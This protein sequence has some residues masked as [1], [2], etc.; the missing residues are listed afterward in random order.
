MPSGSVSIDE[1]DR[2]D[3]AVPAAGNCLDIAVCIGGI[4]EGLAELAYGSIQPSLEVDKSVSRPEMLLQLFPGD[5]LALAFGQQCQHA[6]GLFLEPDPG[7]V[8]ADLAC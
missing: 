5:E 8:P 2:G 4:G 3:E 6:Q 1:F 7:T